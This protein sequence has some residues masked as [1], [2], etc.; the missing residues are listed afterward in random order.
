LSG[1]TVTSALE[2]Y[3]FLLAHTGPLGNLSRRK[4]ELAS[5]SSCTFAYAGLG[6]QLVR[7]HMQ[8]NTPTPRQSQRIASGKAALGPYPD[9][10]LLEAKSRKL[11]LNNLPNDMS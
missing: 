11:L 1:R 5:H 10:P 3:D 4:A 2:I 7:V 6:R 9:H 8:V